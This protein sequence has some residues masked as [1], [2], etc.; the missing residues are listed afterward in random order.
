M[1][2]S[3]AAASSASPGATSI[4]STAAIGSIA[5][6]AA[7][8]LSSVAGG[9]NANALVV[10]AGATATG[11]VAV[12]IFRCAVDAGSRADQSATAAANTARQPAL[13]ASR[14]GQRRAV[15]ARAD[16]ARACTC[17]CSMR[18]T[19][20]TTRSSAAIISRAF[21][22]RSSGRFAIAVS[23]NACQ[24]DF[25]NGRR[26]TGS[27]ACITARPSASGFWNGKRPLTISKVR[28]P[29]L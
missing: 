20:S 6:V 28:T 5:G 9:D 27:I 18:R 26:G 16:T 21:W 13:Q 10:G 19:W 1:I 11:G 2:C 12:S 4:D 23:M 8:A 17:F 15:S 22:K 7:A 14:R 24:C 25:S 3:C 29:R